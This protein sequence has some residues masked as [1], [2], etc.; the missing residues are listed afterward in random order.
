TRPSVVR[1]ELL[2]KVGEP[3]D[4]A[5]FAETERNLRRMGLFRRVSIQP[6]EVDGKL[7]VYVLTSDGWTTTLA[8]N[9]RSTGGV[10]TWSVSPSEGNVAGTGNQIGLGYRKDVDRNVVSGSLG[11]P[12]LGGTRIQTAVAYDYL[13]DGHNLGAILAEP[14]RAFSDNHS[15]TLSF[16]N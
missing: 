11:F 8:L 1:R 2:F 7:V 14:Y 9:A 16:G 15:W 13:S 5:Q 12:R 3:L 4:T 6:R 10:F